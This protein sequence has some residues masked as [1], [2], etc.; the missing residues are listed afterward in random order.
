MVEIKTMPTQATKRDYLKDFHLLQGMLF[1]WI[2]FIPLKNTLYQISVIIIILMF[3][4]HIIQFQTYK[5]LR[6]IFTHT[7]S[8]FFGL[9]MIM[10][11]MLI[12]SLLGLDPS[13]NFIDLLKF[14]YRFVA[15]LFIL[16]YF[17]QQQ[18]FN[19][20]FCVTV[21]IITL[22]LYALDGLYQYV[23]HYDL[24]FH[25]PLEKGGLIGPMFSRNIF[26][27]FMACYASL[28]FY[29]M[30]TFQTIRY[31]FLLKTILVFL[32]FLSLFL[33]FHSLSRASWVAFAIF[34]VLY[35]LFNAKQILLSKKNLFFLML[36]L[37]GVFA[38]F[39]FSP[40]LMNRF[41]SLLQGQDAN[42]FAIWK[43][44][45]ALISHR[46]WFGYGVD[47]SITLLKISVKH[48]HNMIL[49]IALYL[50]IFGIIGY[51]VLLGS[52]YKTIYIIKQYHYAFFLTSFLVLLQF[53][54]GLVNSKVHLS[55]FV[56]YLWFISSHGIDTIIIS[57]HTQKMES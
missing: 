18:F 21:I 46:L 45:L 4:Y 32:F 15:I 7:K 55:I 12:S 27:L 26:G 52:V 28:L 24:L 30:V 54:G 53:D 19:R 17:Y 37:A 1:L 25:K 2:L 49:E 23:T 35:A 50:G 6:I 8:I 29:S 31:S 16:L 56:V 14:F 9:G 42:R 47:A 11:S 51:A 48:V 34:I 36:L 40:A 44:T 43:E 57:N 3:V 10:F 38:L 20:K 41:Q 39:D 13:K 22:T 5:T 33:L